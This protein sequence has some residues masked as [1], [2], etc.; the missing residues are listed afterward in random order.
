MTLSTL[1]LSPA[2][3][4]VVARCVEEIREVFNL[5]SSSK[6]KRKKG[7]KKLEKI[8]RDQIKEDRGEG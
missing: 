6:K 8:L 1:T 3:L 4:E 7:I 2:K 5:N